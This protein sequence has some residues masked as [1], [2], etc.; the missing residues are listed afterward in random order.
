MTSAVPS[1]EYP[2]ALRD[3]LFELFTKCV[4]SAEG[5]AKFKRGVEQVAARA[6]GSWVKE[7][8]LDDRSPRYQQ[9]LQETASIPAGAGRREVQIARILFNQGLFFDCHEYLEPLWKESDG[10]IKRSLQ[11]LIQAGAGFHK[12]ELGS[13]E[14]CARLLRDAADKLKEAPGPGLQAFARALHEASENAARAELTVE[15]A[16]KL[17]ADGLEL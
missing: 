15:Q 9:A 17:A 11:G 1:D 12:L 10:R 14:G 3:E 5:P 7:A 13:P 8:Y 2:L 4:G 6:R 16:P